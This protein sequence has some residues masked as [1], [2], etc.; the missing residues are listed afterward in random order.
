MFRPLTLVVSFLA[1]AAS[2]QPSVE[3]VLVAPDGTPHAGALVQLESGR[4]GPGVVASDTT[5]AEGR[6]RLPVVGPGALGVRPESESLWLPL[7]VEATDAPLTLRLTVSAGSSG[8]LS[9]LEGFEASGSDAAVAQAMEVY[10]SAERRHRTPISSP[11]LDAAVA[12]A[13]DAIASAPLDRKN[14]V[15][16]SL[17]GI[18]AP[19]YEEIVMPR[20]ASFE[21]EA[22]PGD[23]PV[24]RAGRALWRFDKIHA[25]S[26]GAVA[27]FR[28]VPPSSPLWS[29]EGGS[30]SGV[31]NVL[32]QMARH[33]VPTEASIPAPFEAYLRALAYDYPD[34]NVRAQASG[35]LHNLLVQTG[36][37]REAEI[38]RE[39]LLREHPDSYQAERLRRAD[40]ADRRVR[41]GQPIADFAFPS[42]ADSTVAITSADLRGKTYLID[43]WGTWCVPCVKELP[44]L[45]DLYETYRD[46]GF[47]IV[48]VATFDSV[49]AVAAF[50]DDGF[51]MP[52]RHALLPD[53]DMEPTRETFEFN[54]IPAYVLV[55][56]DGVILAE[57]A[58]ASGD[59]LTAALA[60]HFAGATEE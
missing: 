13:E 40:A 27:V 6:F 53:A 33:L 32:F 14:A 12:E 20:F 58:G 17:Q 47:E 42:L 57:G 35:V 52:W 16:D 11:A 45:H 38:A 60:E 36:V 26:A 29:F 50:R 4:L 22:A 48:S 19:L 28:D 1:V 7:A 21:A 55:G 18:I 49:E 39:R 25:D 59:N 56:P 8:P 46:D 2:A 54:G 44:R 31:N 34:P 51:P 9:I 5:D 37:G 23:P 30:Q 41:P 24:V 3:G 43:F 15:R 10:V